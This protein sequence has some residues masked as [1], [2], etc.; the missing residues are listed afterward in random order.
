[1]N[2]VINKKPK[3]AICG[4]GV[5]G[6]KHL[7]V[8]QNL[9]FDIVST[10]DPKVNNNISYNLFLSTLLQVD[11]IIVSSPTQYH[12]HNI[13]DAINI[14]PNIKI[15]CEKPICNSSTNKELNQ[16]LD[17]SK[18][19][20]VGQIE[21]FNS[22]Y[23]MLKKIIDIKD[24]I[25]IRSRR[26]SDTPPRE[27]IDCRLDIGIHDLDLCINLLDRFPEEV[28]IIS[29]NDFSHETLFYKIQNIQI[30]NEISWRYPFKSRVIE[31]LTTKGLY[32]CNLLEQ[33]I[34]FV[35][36]LG[37]KT[38][39]DFI[40]EPSLRIELIEFA[41]MCLFSKDSVSTVENNIKLLQLMGY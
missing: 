31:I 36:K 21:R 7:R 2:T 20:M 25:Q 9:G 22:A 32:I 5:M 39:I 19:I 16:I 4:L 35:D 37:H 24:I 8:A 18:S 26:V 38:N 41:N 15:L 3:I 6:Q 1:M 28:S 13:I 33:T 29:N 27:S 12:T 17:W 23:I 10:Y 34:V 30:I 14:N 11:G 40:K